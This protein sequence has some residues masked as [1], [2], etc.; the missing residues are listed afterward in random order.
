MRLGIFFVLRIQPQ[1]FQ[2]AVGVKIDNSM[3]DKGEKA[4]SSKG[5]EKKFA[6]STSVFATPNTPAAGFA[7]TGFANTGFGG[8]E[9]G[10]FG[11][12]EPSNFGNNSFGGGRGRGSF[13]G[14]GAN[15]GGRVRNEL[16]GHDDRGQRAPFNGGGYGQGK[17][18]CT[19]F[20]DRGHCF[21]GDNCRFLHEVRGEGSSRNRSR[22]RSRN[23]RR[24]SPPSR[25][26]TPARRRRDTNS[27][28]RSRSRSRDNGAH[29]FGRFPGVAK[30]ESSPTDWK[31]P[32][33]DGPSTSRNGNGRRSPEKPIK[34]RRSSSSS[35]DRESS[36]R[37]NDC[38]KKALGKLTK[39]ISKMS[40]VQD[41]ILKL[42]Q[43]DRE[44]KGRKSS[45]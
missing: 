8:G 24:E 11:N 42:L 17:K 45:K 30:K 40:K 4:E 26:R 22:S 44:P 39:K 13:R 37:M 43:E 9:T 31:R 12:R 29:K 41:A 7:N 6:N 2:I 1:A 35:S 25:S 19:Y 32:S 10:G 36:P 21:N 34:R 15:R 33:K 20:T 38:C 18:P 23:D 16:D 14:G 28:S 3:S 27:R 5:A